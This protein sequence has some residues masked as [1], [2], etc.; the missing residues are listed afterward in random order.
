MTLELYVDLFYEDRELV[1]TLKELIQQN[2]GV[3][4][5]KVKLKPGLPCLFSS[6]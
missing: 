6:T 5:H 3:K 2:P 1:T 4:K